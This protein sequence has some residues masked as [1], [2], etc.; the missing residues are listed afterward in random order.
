MPLN[1]FLGEFSW[2]PPGWLR[3]IGLRR[4]AWSLL[5]SVALAVVVA[6]G[7]V[8]YQ[9]LPQPLRTV[10]VIDPPG[11]TP[12]INGDLV[13]EPLRLNFAYAADALPPDPPRLSAARLDLVDQILEQG[14]ELRPA[15]PGQWRF[16]N[17]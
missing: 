8:I 16:R 1:T 10:V 17:G 12:I 7:V 5:A 15:V 13:P 4:A 14:V 2:S 3:R 9:G 6:G 11:V